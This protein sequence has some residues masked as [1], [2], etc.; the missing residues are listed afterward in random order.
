VE[1]QLPQLHAPAC[2]P[3]NGRPRTQSSICVQGCRAGLGPR[4]R[5][6]DILAQIRAA[7][8]LQPTAPRATAASPPCCSAT[9]QV[10]HST[11]LLMLREST[12][13]CR[14]GAPTRPRT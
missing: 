14:C 6:A 3:L 11:G 8:V 7:A 2:R 4:E 9:A 5:V 12:R 10:D 1:L 13:R